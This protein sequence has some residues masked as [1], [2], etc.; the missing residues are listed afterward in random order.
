M[1]VIINGAETGIKPDNLP[2]I[3]DIVELIKAS[4]DPDHMITQLLLD[5]REL[6]DSDW[7]APCGTHSTAIIEVETNTP[8]AFVTDRMSKAA[9]VV[10]ECYMRFRDARKSFQAGD[11]QRGNQQL[12]VAVDT[13]SAFFEW[14]GVI[15]DLV[16]PA[17]RGRYEITQQVT[18]ISGI[19][20]RI[21]QQQLYQSWWA[22]GETIE[23][24][25]E[26]KLDGLEDFCRKFETEAAAA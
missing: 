22:L 12:V 13:A 24:E 11:T 2:R 14:Y 10:R 15:L 1:R 7:T 6:A 19:C 18:E 21:C 3:A 8:H 26:P 23:R 25:L 5:G 4:I 16:P 20:K 17:D 9:A